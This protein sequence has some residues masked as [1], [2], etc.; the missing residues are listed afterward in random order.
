MI[1]PTL[2]VE[3]ARAALAAREKGEPWS[4]TAFVHWTGDGEK[5]DQGRADSLLQKLLA[6]QTELGSGE[7]L[8]SHRGKDFEGPASAFVHAELDIPSRV[9][10]SREFWLW[11]TFVA[12]DGEFAELVDWRFGS[13]DIIDPV[14]YGVGRR[15]TIWE[16]LFARLW[17][18]GNIGFDAAGGDPYRIAKKGDIDIWRSHIIRQEYGRSRQ[19]AQALIEF[20]YPDQSAGK[21]L[22]VKELREL[23]K[24]LR[25]ADASIS[26]E[27]LD[28]G[29][30]KDLIE[31]NVERIREIERHDAGATG[32]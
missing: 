17:L 15:S 12:C 18:R 22:K 6:V 14:N 24:R 20:Q 8:P 23:A 21:P 25:I 29:S 4:G 28:D 26:Y 5:F 19:V 11:L 27:L 3:A 16:G 13:K 7:P 2:S 9:A 1:F 10:G 32:P 30:I 31:E